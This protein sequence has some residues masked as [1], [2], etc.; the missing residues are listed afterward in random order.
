[1]LESF[2]FLC[3][4]AELIARQ[5][6]ELI[7]AA[8]IDA[9]DFRAKMKAVRKVRNVTEHWSDLKRSRART[10]H[11]HVTK[12]GE[13]AGVDEV[14]LVYYYYDQVYRGPLKRCRGERLHPANARDDPKQ[15]AE[16]VSELRWL[17]HS[18]LNAIVGHAHEGLASFAAVSR[19]G[20]RRPP[21]RWAL[22]WPHA[23][24]RRPE[25]SRTVWLSAG[26]R[27]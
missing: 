6:P 24:E 12:D 25:T 19:G 11:D 23:G 7:T 15:A 8:G 27:R 16:E 22:E 26:H 3:A 17:R 13:F 2:L 4:R 1:M 21:G 20:L 9:D 5:A 14:L 18:A 10:M